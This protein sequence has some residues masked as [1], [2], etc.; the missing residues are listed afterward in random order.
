MLRTWDLDEGL[1]GLRVRLGLRSAVLDSL[2]LSERPVRVVIDG[3]DNSGEPAHIAAAAELTRAAAELPN[4]TVLITC[5][6]LALDRVFSALRSAGAQ[7]PAPPMMLGNLSADE[8]GEVLAQRE[9]L[10]QLAEAGDLAAVLERPKLLD[11]VLQV[12][13]RVGPQPLT[14][15]QDEAAIADVWWTRIATSGQH[16]AQ[17][18]ELLT[19]LAVSQADA[20]R[21]SNCA[22]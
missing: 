21:S 20:L 8:L 16:R 18:A 2:R 10:R 1:A 12:L 9:D 22:R 15:A 17:R 7:L 19:G 3:L 14:G 13:D 6:E 5:N 11:L 4:V